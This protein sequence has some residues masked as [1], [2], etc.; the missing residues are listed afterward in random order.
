M[1]KSKSTVI[2]SGPSVIRL[3]SSPVFD[4]WSKLIAPLLTRLIDLVDERLIDVRNRDGVFRAVGKIA[5]GV[6]TGG[7]ERLNLS[8]FELL[9]EGAVI[10][11]RLA[12][13]GLDE[14]LDD[15]EDG[16]HRAG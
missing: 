5:D 7:V 16:D 2:A 1:K 12:F 11:P 15:D 3:E 8:G 9:V 10:E 13:A 14:P 6:E 4:C